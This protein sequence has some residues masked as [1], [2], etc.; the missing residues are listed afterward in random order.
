MSAVELF[1]E[2][3]VG[4]TERYG[5]NQEHIEEKAPQQEEARAFQI[6]PVDDHN[7]VTHRIEHRQI[8][9]E[10]I[11]AVDRGGESG[12]QGERHGGQKHPHHRLLHRIRQCGNA[13]SRADRRK[14]ECDEPKVEQGYG[15]VER[16]PVPEQRNQED[17]GHLDEPHKDVGRGFCRNDFTRTVG[18]DEQLVE[19]AFLPFPRNGKRRHHHGVQHCQ[20]RQ[21]SGNHEETHVVVRIVPGA[22]LQ[23]DRRLRQ[24]VLFPEFCIEFADDAHGVAHGDVRGI[25]VAPVEDSL[26]LGG[27]PVQEL[28]CEILLKCQPL[29][30]CLA[31]DQ[32]CHCFLICRSRFGFEDAGAVE[33]SEHFPRGASPVAVDEAVIDVRQVECRG[34]SEYD[35]LDKRRK[36]HED[37]ALRI[38][39][40]RQHL[41]ADQCGQ[42]GKEITHIYSSRFGVFHHARQSIRTAITARIRA[43][44]TIT[45]QISPARN[46]VCMSVT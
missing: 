8:L 24:I 43:F 18:G 35:D 4:G 12:E 25:R 6:D 9:E 20:H 37:A 31:V 14:N 26:N 42:S 36:Q 30:N 17:H 45:L 1:L 29:K 15:T 34:I 33:S 23:S 27:L 46:R 5:G 11:H 39:E 19:G 22:F 10:I 7:A 41:L 2:N 21:Q 44:G 32:V 3:G 38:F 16:N 40:D 28:S 13:Q